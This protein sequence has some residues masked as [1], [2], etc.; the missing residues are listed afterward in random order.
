MGPQGLEVIEKFTNG[1][2]A[3]EQELEQAEQQ[4]SAAHAYGPRRPQ[5]PHGAEGEGEEEAGNEGPAAVSESRV[6]KD[7]NGLLDLLAPRSSRKSPFPLLGYGRPL[8]RCIEVRELDPAAVALTFPADRPA[9]HT[10]SSPLH[11]LEVNPAFE[12]S[13]L[14]SRRQAQPALSKGESGWGDATVADDE[15]APDTFL[16]SA[17]LEVVALEEGRHPGS[18]EPY[19]PR[20]LKPA[21]DVRDAFALWAARPLP[22]A[23]P[24]P[25]PE[26]R[27]PNQQSHT[28]DTASE[29][30]KQG[31]TADAS[32]EGEETR[33]PH[34]PDR[35]PR[36]WLQGLRLLSAEASSR[37]ELDV[38]TQ[39][40]LA[41]GA[42][43][44][45][46]VV[47][48]RKVFASSNGLAAAS[49][50]VVP[51]NYLGALLF[52]FFLVLLD[53]IAYSWGSQKYKALL[54]FF[55]VSF[56]LGFLTRVFWFFPLL[57]GAWGHLR[58][59][60][61]LKCIKLFYSA[62]QLRSGLFLGAPGSSRTSFYWMT[63]V[64]FRHWLGGFIF[65]VVPFLYECRLIL[66]W[67]C[68]WVPFIAAVASSGR[69]TRLFPLQH[70][71]T[72]AHGLVQAHRDHQVRGGREFC[73][74]AASNPDRPGGFI[75]PRTLY[76]TSFNR[77]V[78]QQRRMGDR[79]P[80]WRK[81]VHGALFLSGL[82]LVLWVP[83]LIF[84]STNPVYQ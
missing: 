55:E 15:E 47:F 10:P 70:D 82:F 48:F 2:L 24:A 23:R 30:Q 78:R 77:K 18:R 65:M 67:I 43:F 53:R 32:G 58:A 41:D 38:Y 39:Q 84:A 74:D 49:A 83:L 33:V 37:D 26:L 69:L 8:L 13:T 40:F 64:D 7:T 50:G 35:D 34:P 68:R 63:Q 3:M 71:H 42:A 56:Y 44:F 5:L 45:Y 60:A 4:E 9:R 52:Q 76:N 25:E 12:P 62:R 61:L 1:A 66:D 29:Q 80:R 14:A 79:E 16:F 19:A 81:A 17:L 54:H 51:G 28:D 75:R 21:E 57:P 11:N 31:G 20:L 72:H 27:Q 6:A 36:T 46:S 73:D 59:F 22:E